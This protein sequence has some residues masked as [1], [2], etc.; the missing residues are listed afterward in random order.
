MKMNKSFLLFGAILIVAFSQPMDDDLIV[1]SGG[2]VITM[3]GETIENSVVKIRNGIIERVE[4]IDPSAWDSSW[5]DVSGKIIL[6]GFILLHSGLGMLEKEELIAFHNINPTSSDFRILIDLG[7]TR[8]N[9]FSENIETQ[10]TSLVATNFS[11]DYLALISGYFGLI[12]SLEESQ[13]SW[14]ERFDSISPLLTS[15]PYFVSSSKIGSKVLSSID[16]PIVMIWEELNNNNFGESSFLVSP[17]HDD[18]RNGKWFPAIV[19]AAQKHREKAFYFPS[20][21]YQTAYSLRHMF[22]DIGF[23]IANGLPQEEALRMLTIYPARILGVDDLFG[24]VE[25]GKVADLVIFGEHPFQTQSQPDL[26]I[27]EGKIVN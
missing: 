25:K 3:T 1:L 19:N 14:L 8:C 24:S 5:I 4:T 20:D 11:E 23:L 2:T 13:K 6:P 10:G 26:V 18:E 16:Y 12:G 7:F 21:V 9:I 15:K 17:F 27:I 22:I